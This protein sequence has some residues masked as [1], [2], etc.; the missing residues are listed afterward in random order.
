MVLFVGENWRAEVPRCRGKP[1]HKA[2][3]KGRQ[4]EE[5]EERERVTQGK[6]SMVLFMGKG[7]LRAFLHRGARRAAQRHNSAAAHRNTKQSARGA[8]KRRE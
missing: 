4:E 7:F 6:G 3:R 1:R 2:E 8:R 5:G